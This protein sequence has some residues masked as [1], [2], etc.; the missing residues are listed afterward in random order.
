MIRKLVFGLALGVSAFAQAP[1]PEVQRLQ[2]ELEKLKLQKEVADAQVALLKAGVPES[3]VKAPDATITSDSF[4]RAEG[5][6]FDALATEAK[7]VGDRIDDG[8]KLNGTPCDPARCSV[9]F[10]TDADIQDLLLYRGATGQLAILKHGYEVTLPPPGPPQPYAIPSALVAAPQI[11]TGLVGSIAELVALFR[12]NTAIAGTSFTIPVTAAVAEVAGNIKHARVYYPALDPPG[13]NTATESA[14]LQQLQEVQTLAHRAG[15]FV[16][17]SKAEGEKAEA[18]AKAARKRV[19]ELATRLQTARKSKEQQKV[20]AAEKELAA[21]QADEQQ[22]G[23]RLVAARQ[24]LAKNDVLE[25]LDR[26]FTQLLTTLATP[27][28]K[29]GVDKLQRALAVEPAH[30]KAAQPGAFLARVDFVR[31]TGERITR[32]SLWHNSLRHNGGV[33][34]AYALF[35]YQGALVLSGTARKVLSER[36]D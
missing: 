10:V 18:A 36:E 24:A 28:A 17:D 6:A 9:I 8:L 7:A 23:N 26:Q 27:D 29:T 13:L 32:H 1:D 22:A 34:L 25:S 12:S 15:K 30:A 20:G 3:K 21:A 16:T 11:A 4:V 31:A 14:L 5:L 2:A 35:D 19:E 33:I